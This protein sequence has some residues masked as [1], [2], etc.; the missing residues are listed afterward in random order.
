M[1]LPFFLKRQTILH[2][3]PD[4][5]YMDVA[6]YRIS[7]IIS[8]KSHQIPFMFF[9][10]LFMFFSFALNPYTFIFQLIFHSYTIK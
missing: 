4:I 10:K 8:Q 1:Q 6:I 7:I 9:H 5:T 2:V 3:M